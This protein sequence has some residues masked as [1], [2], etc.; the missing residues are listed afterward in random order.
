LPKHWQQIS[1]HKKEIHSAS[2]KHQVSELQDQS[3]L[4][5]VKT[6]KIVAPIYTACILTNKE[7]TCIDLIHA[8]ISKLWEITTLEDLEQEEMTH[9][10]VSS[11]VPYQKLS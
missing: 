7:N 1:E 8:L 11:Q 5:L 2:S 9:A 4:F 10:F 3:Y 6:S